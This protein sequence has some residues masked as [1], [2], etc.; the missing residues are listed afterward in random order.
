MSL[1][2]NSHLCELN[3]YGGSTVLYA[4]VKHEIQLANI[5][6]KSSWVVCLNI[7]QTNKNANKIIGNIP[8]KM[9]DV[10]LVLI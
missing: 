7:Q 4:H 3:R 5:Y 9:Y 6:G 10:V 1:F 8:E 2:F